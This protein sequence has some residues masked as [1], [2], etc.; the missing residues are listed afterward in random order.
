[1]DCWDKREELYFY[2]VLIRGGGK[3]VIINTGPPPDLTALSA[4]WTSTFGQHG[5]LVRREGEA[6]E[7][8]LGRIGVTPA[9]V[10]IRLYDPEVLERF[11]EGKVA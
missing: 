7:M 8:A 4:C 6:P 1:M 11:P 10:V 9:D 5:A 2:M 3:V